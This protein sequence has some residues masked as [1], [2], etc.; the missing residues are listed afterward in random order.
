[1]TPGG[2]A[3]T[4][5]HGVRAENADGLVEA[6]DA[7]RQDQMPAASQCSI[8]FVY[9]VGRLGDKEVANRDRRTGRWSVPPSNSRGVSLQRW[10][11]NV[12]IAGR[13]DVEEGLLPSHRAL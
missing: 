7:G 4:E 11:E 10:D 2:E 6:V 5:Y 9:V 8:N 13:I 3:Q 1:M 12:E